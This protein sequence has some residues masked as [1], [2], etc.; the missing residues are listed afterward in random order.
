MKKYLL[1][2]LAVYPLLLCAQKNVDLDRFRFRVNYMM[3]PK[4]P[5]DVAYRTYNVKVN[6]P[7][8]MKPY[9]DQI[10]PENRVL[11]ANWKQLPENGHISIMVKLENLIP[12]AVSVKERIQTTKNK[13]GVITSTKTFY[14]QEVVYSF[15]AQASIKDYKGNPVGDE[16]LA[17]RNDKQVY[18]SPEFSLKGMAE[19]Y[20]VL[21]AVQIN[22]DLY[23]GSINRALSLLS[24]RI[25]S[26][27]GFTETTAS[28]F[29]WIIGSRKHPEYADNRRMMLLL[30]EVLFT[31]SAKTPIDGAREKLK[32][33]IDYFEKVK[34]NY[35]STS[36][37]DRK[38]RYSSFYN[39]AVLYYYLDDPQAMMN[40]ANGLA[41]N[42]YDSKD[43][44]G[45]MQT[46]TS[47]K[48]EMEQNKV[49]SRHLNIDPSVFKGPL[50]KSS[51]VVTK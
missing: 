48:S 17:D 47:L 27:F 18:R 35:L 28:D 37:H 6:G 16:I 21:N 29:M 9:L 42:D 40:Q 30:Q 3:L 50:E 22:K 7:D 43:A 2:C 12:E 51:P 34:T 24:D 14:R 13:E 31:L 41:L 44:R 4:A 36:K 20:F 15:A 10:N 26:N 19:G 1:C 8:L 25:S 49:Q 39:L 11:L 23:N 33:A 38:M 45:F 46:A 5:L 32:P